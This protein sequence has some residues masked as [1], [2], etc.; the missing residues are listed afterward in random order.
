VH[1]IKFRNLTVH[2]YE[3]L[4]YNIVILRSIVW[5]LFFFIIVDNQKQSADRETTGVKAI[6]GFGKFCGKFSGY[7]QI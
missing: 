7:F 4:F 3:I 1:F 2:F 5:Q 6:H